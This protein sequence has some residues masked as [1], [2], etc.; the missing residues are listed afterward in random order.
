M[1]QDS[2]LPEVPG[3][4]R[5]RLGR[6]ADLRALQE[7]QCMAEWRPGGDPRAAIQV[8]PRSRIIASEAPAS[9]ARGEKKSDSASKSAYG[10]PNAPQFSQPTPE[11]RRPDAL[12]A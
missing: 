11:L 6:R 1:S 9:R 2:R 10:D 5:Q 3:G 7:Q 4:L 12:C 8:V